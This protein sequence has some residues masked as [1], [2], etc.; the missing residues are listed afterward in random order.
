[1]A[2]DVFI[3]V[4]ALH[5]AWTFASWGALALVML[6]Y[7]GLISLEVWLWRAMTRRLHRYGWETLQKRRIA[8]EKAKDLPRSIKAINR[9][10]DAAM[11]QLTAQVAELRSMHCTCDVAPELPGVAHRPGCPV[12]RFEI[13]SD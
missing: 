4:A 2:T 8:Q 5:D 3:S 10:I 11:R 9:E 1:V 6:F 13:P 7:A 12:R